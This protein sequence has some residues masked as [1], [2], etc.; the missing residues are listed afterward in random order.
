MKKYWKF[1]LIDAS[2][3][4]VFASFICWNLNP[5]EWGD[6]VRLC[7][8]ILFILSIYYKLTK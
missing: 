1:L 3:L 2:W 8:V 4:Y 7:Y 5:Y 6:F